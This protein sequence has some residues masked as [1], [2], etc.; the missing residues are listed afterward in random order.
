MQT[1]FGF[2]PGKIVLQGR[3]FEI[4]TLPD[5][6]KTAEELAKSGQVHR[7]WVY[8]PAKRTGDLSGEISVLP[9]PA[10]VFGLPKS[11]TLSHGDSYGKEYSQFLVWCL[12]FF[13]GMRLTTTEAGFVD[14][15]PLKPHALVDFHVMPRELGKPMAFAEDYWTAT[16]ADSQRRKLLS[17]IVHALFLAQNPRFLQYE[18]FIHLYAAL[19]SAFALYRRTASVP[20][21]RHF[22]RIDWMC[23][24]FGIATP[25]WAQD[26]GGNSEA[27][28]LRNPTFHEALFSSEPLGFAIYRGANSNSQDENMLLEM[29]AL[30]CRFIVAL[31]GKPDSPYV[32]SPVTTRQMHSFD[33]A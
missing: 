9:F 3:S 23:K 1:P 32:R 31:M 21:L 11:H 7:D 2:Y 22:Q 4:A 15:T 13:V 18:R 29:Q 19:D 14:A 20:Y 30:T 28:S 16:Q 5:V 27:A 6:E 12:S 33:L 26:T 17:A 10:R 24:A 25:T 8:P